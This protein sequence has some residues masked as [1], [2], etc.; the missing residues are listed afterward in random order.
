[1]TFFFFLYLILIVAPIGTLIHESGHAFGA[2]LVKAN[3][4]TL[5]IGRGKKIGV[6]HFQKIQMH[7]RLLYFLGGFTQSKRKMPYNQKEI[8]C[9]TLFGP[10]NNAIF[11]ILFYLLYGMYANQ[12]L[13]ILFLF[14][15]WL[16]V[17]NMLP[18]KFKGKQS[19]GYS[20]F[21]HFF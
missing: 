10:L 20:I 18:F 16:A 15:L 4:I 3:Q 12:Y 14:N 13:H 6:I 11:A 7:I 19:D 21:K 2:N 5:S 8:V 17:V 9:I 1:M